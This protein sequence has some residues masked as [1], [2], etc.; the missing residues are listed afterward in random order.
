MT[1]TENSPAHAGGAGAHD[2]TA[3]APATERHEPAAQPT[4]Q[5]PGLNTD[6]VAMGAIFVAIFAFLAAVFAV[7]LAS[8]AV[9]EARS[10]GGGAAAPAGGGAA[11]VSVSLRE[12][13]IV[14]STLEVPAGTSTIQVVNEGA[15]PHN[16]DIEGVATA[17]LD[18]GAE[19]SLDISS[20]AP[21]TYTMICTIPGHESA[22]MS[23][24]ITIG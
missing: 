3:G 2:A 16:L 21:G 13:E 12:F 11:A 24:T 19:A 18:G 22:G 14:P 17:D 9:D 6:T 5:R 10:G 23:G 8:R 4:P 7:A 1:L 20:L 15:I